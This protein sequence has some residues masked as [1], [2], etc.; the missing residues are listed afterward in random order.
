MS[1][2]CLISIKLHTDVYSNKLLNSLSKTSVWYFINS[3]L[4]SQ[5]TML[6]SSAIE[7]LYSDT[8]TCF[9]QIIIWYTKSDI[10]NLRSVANVRFAYNGPLQMANLLGT[11]ESAL[12]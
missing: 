9:S 6:L 12:N 7:C 3:G 4:Q 11:I 2:L 8:G 5:F 1:R 10:G